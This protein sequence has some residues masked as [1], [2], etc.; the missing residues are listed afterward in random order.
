LEIKKGKVLYN[1]TTKKVYPL[2]DNESEIILH[3]KDDLAEK[4]AKQ[5]SV[6]NKGKVNAKMTSIIFKFLE[7]YHIKTHFIKK[8]D[9]SDILV[10]KAEILPFKVVI[11]NISDSDFSKKYKIKKG[12]VLEYPVVEYYLKNKEIKYPMISPDFACTFGYTSFEEMKQI[13]GLSRKINAVLKSFLNRRKLSLCKLSLEFGR[14]QDKI[15]LVDEIS[16]DSVILYNLENGEEFFSGFSSLY[17]GYK[18]LD[19]KL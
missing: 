6:K 5:S 14:I 11:W 2:M 3:F 17:E 9:E 15:V 4:N 1:G 8:L 12:D 13:D 19:E 10:K 18:V 7:S 16:C